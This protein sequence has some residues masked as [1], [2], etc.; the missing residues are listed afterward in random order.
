MLF[1]TNSLVVWPLSFQELEE[2]GSN[3]NTRYDM[4][5]PTIAKPNSIEEVS[6]KKLILF[7]HF[8]LH[9]W[10]QGFEDI[11]I[12]RQ[13]PFSSSLQCMSVI[14]REL[15]KP[16]M[17]AYTKGAPEKVQTMCLSATVPL[18]FN[19]QLS[20]FTIK[21]YRVIAVAYKNLPT[22]FTWKTA[23]KTKRDVVSFNKH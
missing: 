5:A 16:Y 20:Q 3:E 7:T 2:P 15:S 9:F 19:A 23:Q 21:G 8:Y 10:I 18:D 11:G 6:L 17:V 1:S 22:N 4:L 14:C 12:V 13:F